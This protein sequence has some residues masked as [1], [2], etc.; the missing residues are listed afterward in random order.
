MKFNYINFIN[1]IAVS[2]TEAKNLS[3]KDWDTEA[4]RKWRHKLL[5]SICRIE[6]QGYKVNCNLSVR[7]FRV[8]GYGITSKFEQDNIFNKDL[9]D[10]INELEL[11]I[12]QYKNYGDPSL[13]K[14]DS[15]K[16]TAEIKAIEVTEKITMRWLFDHMPIKGWVAIIGLLA[17]TFVLGYKFY[18]AIILP[19]KEKINSS[20]SKL[21]HDKAS[22]PS[23]VLDEKPI[24][25]IAKPANS[26]K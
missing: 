9:A 7:R 1:E 15:Q 11:I 19:A 16:N 20:E 26:L 21:K 8:F 5:D 2:I 14:S 10:T 3:P 6:E 4:F 12:E 17:G 18:E 22:L 13:N 23:N 25:N 24:S